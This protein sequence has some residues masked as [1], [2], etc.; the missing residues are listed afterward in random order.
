VIL[1]GR[2]HL[3]TEYACEDGYELENEKRAHAY[4]KRK[5]WIGDLPKCIPAKSRRSCSVSNGGCAQLC[6]QDNRRLV[7]CSCKPGYVLQPDKKTC[8]DFDECEVNGGD[9]D[10]I[11]DN[12]EGSFKCSCF[13]GYTLS[14]DRTNCNRTTVED[15]GKRNVNQ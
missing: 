15:N 14:S 9:C 1:E 6:K 7:S 10:H 3:Y 12:T 8:A 11:C 13:P 2:P 4:C 5:T